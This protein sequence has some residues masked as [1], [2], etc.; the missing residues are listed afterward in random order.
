[1]VTSCNSPISQHLD[2]HTH[3]QPVQLLFKIPKHTRSREKTHLKVF[4][5][6]KIVGRFNG[7][8]SKLFHL[9]VELKYKFDKHDDTLIVLAIYVLSEP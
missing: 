2:I 9:F 7:E 3:Q 6:I 1:M 8:F 4:G 5:S